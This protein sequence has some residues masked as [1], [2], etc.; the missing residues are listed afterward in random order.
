[1]IA[2]AAARR[3]VLPEGMAVTARAAVILATLLAAG[4]D[5]R[6]GATA[7]AGPD[8]GAIDGYRPPLSGLVPAIGSAATLDLACWNIENFPATA[9]TPAIV[10]DL[11][12]S[13]DLDL[14]VVEEIASDAA[15]NE[16]LARLPEHDGVLSTHR[17]TPTSYQKIGLIYR[18]AIATVG[19]PELLFVTDSYGFPRPPF[20][21]P[22]TVGALTV[23][24]IGVHLKAGT[25]D[26]DAARR[27]AAAR[28]L[29]AYLRAQVDGG[30]E[31]EVIVLGDYNERIT[32]AAGQAVLAPLLAADR[33]VLRSAAAANA[34]AAT[35]L[36]SGSAIDH[37]LTTAG[38]ADEVGAR[39]AVVVPL[40]QQY[41]GYQRQV[42][43]HV[44]VALSFPMP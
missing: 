8:D 10:A 22:V 2:L 4:C 11:I 26:E 14:V 44:P 3:S 27:A 34:G 37:I 13:L 19:T 5:L 38:L 6:D 40:G 30:G 18:P 32:T 29:D 28:S 9:D 42:S 24:V 15:W 41:P 36:P 39:D 25:T 33:Y 12:T 43:D 17:Y 16:L 35:F 23:D 1:M 21:V 7:D 20:R 31:D